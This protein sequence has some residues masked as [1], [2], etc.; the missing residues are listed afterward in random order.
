M[1][2][3]HVPQNTV[4]FVNPHFVCCDK[5]WLP[6]TDIDGK[7]CTGPYSALEGRE[8]DSS[9]PFLAHFYTKTKEEWRKR[10]GPE[11]IRAD[12]AQYVTEDWFD[13]ENH[14][15]KQFTLLAERQKGN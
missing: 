12:C 3:E 11:H 9:K 6:W 8:I 14:N 2:L 10:R 7:L 15:E 13:R 4:R 5:F 1:N